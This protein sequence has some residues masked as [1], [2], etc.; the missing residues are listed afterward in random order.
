ME[1]VFYSSPPAL[2]WAKPFL[3]QSLLS[4]RFSG[5]Q[6]GVLLIAA[7]GETTRA[8]WSLDR[9]LLG[10]T[11]PLAPPATRSTS[12]IS[13]RAVTAGSFSTLLQI[14]T[15]VNTSPRNSNKFLLDHEWYIHWLATSQGIGCSMT[16]WQHPRFRPCKT[17]LLHIAA[18]ATWEVLWSA[19]SQFEAHVLAVRGES[20]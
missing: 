2:P 15:S 6:N 13:V 16:S 17:F 10:A 14:L 11:C 1:H 7:S 19:W 4:G 18:S 9:T 12:R 8:G 5:V 3:V 20:Q